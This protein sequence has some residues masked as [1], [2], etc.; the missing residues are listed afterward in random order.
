MRAGS[1]ATLPSAMHETLLTLV[2]LVS[3]ARLDAAPSQQAGSSESAGQELLQSAKP[4]QARDAFESTLN[5]N[6]ANVEAQHGEV[7]ASERLAL[8][9]RQAGHAEEALQDL[10]RAQRF[11][12]TY[13]RLLYDLGILED[14][15]QLYRDADQTLLALEQL[16]PSNPQ[17]MYAVARVKLDLGQLA[18]AEKRMQAYLRLQ[19]NDASAH[20]GLG[21]IYQLGLH[22]DEARAEL[23]RSIEL[24]P[25]QTE[26]YY[27]LGDIALGQGD[28]D[29]AIASFSKT[30]TRDPKHGGALAGTG[31]ALFKQK[32]Y[33]QAEDF[34][35]RAVAAAPG[36]QSGHYY[37]GLTLARLGCKEDSQRE[38]ARA[39]QLVEEQ[40]K[41][42]RGLHL[43]P[44]THGP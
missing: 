38:L 27:Q 17:V 12:P 3:T 15:M 43:D 34:L 37:L 19:P 7:A 6:P 14:E 16:Q 35:E 32:R 30:L 39:T 40:A 41:K 10:L 42:N 21:R 4:A 25:L 1:F 13:P 31:Q 33:A 23:Q 5:S 8:D 20:Y 29:E 9:A 22:F 11:A 28:L 18:E 44:S 26:A 2:L 36:Y 24:Q